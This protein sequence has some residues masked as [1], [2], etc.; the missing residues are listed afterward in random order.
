MLNAKPS[1][2]VKSIVHSPE[3][4][5]AANVAGEL[6][7]LGVDKGGFF[8]FNQV[9]NRVWPYLERPIRVADLCETLF[10]QYRA[11]EAEIERDVILFLND[12]A[13]NGL[14]DVR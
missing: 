13:R 4:L 3:N 7:V 10:R 2:T 6:V 1:I 12:L 5:Q 9:G 14:L 11:P 8:G